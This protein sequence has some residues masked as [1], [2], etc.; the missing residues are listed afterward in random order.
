MSVAVASI[1]STALAREILP[2]LGPSP[3]RR[4]VRVWEETWRLT[5]RLSYRTSRWVMGVRDVD[6]TGGVVLEVS[7]PEGS[8]ARGPAIGRGDITLRLGPGWD[9]ASLSR[10]I[11][12]LTRKAHDFLRQAQAQA[13]VK[14]AVEDHLTAT[15]GDA[16]VL[17]RLERAFA[18]R[19]WPIFYD[20][21]T[22]PQCEAILAFLAE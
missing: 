6:L 4:D 22:E 21:M 13:K 16:G 2:L 9:E 7:A 12:R 3:L 5:V 20:A 17:G 15:P 8:A 11:H 1:V 10:A 19:G 18:D 14:D